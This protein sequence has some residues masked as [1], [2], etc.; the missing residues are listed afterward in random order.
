M[1]AT[2]NGAG[3]AS[4]F[5]PIAIIGMSSKFSGDAT[6][7]EKLWEMLAGGRSG[8]TPFPSSRFRLQGI[9]HP[10]NERL[11]STH[12]K[13]AHFLQEDIG[14]F[15]A[16]FFGYSSEAAASLDPQ[17]RLQLESVYEALESAGLPIS[18]IAGSNA[19]VFTG[20]F[21]HD[22]RDGLLR[23]ADNL[24]RLMATGTGV[25]MMS[26]RVSHFFDLRGASM[27]IE[28]ACSSGMVAMH[29]GI[30]S[31]RTGEADM[32]IV[33]G[34]NLTLNPDMFKALGSAG[35]LSGDGKSY[36]L[37]S[38]ASGYGRG[39]GVA[40]IIIKRLG[41][42]LA[43]GDP[44]RGVI[45]GSALN[46]DGKT[47]TI[48]TPSLEAQEA[49]IRAC[50]ENAGLSPKDTQ[51]FEA[52]GT[53]TQAGDTIEA[54]A[55]A[56]VF[57]SSSEPLLIGSVK[58]N[59][60]H[61]EAASG[62]ASIVKTVLALERGVIPPSIN[63]EKPNPK[64]PLED[65]RLRL[66][67]TLETWPAAAV[68]R[69]SINNF[70]YGGANAHIIMEESTP[71]LPALGGENGHAD[72]RSNE[73]PQASCE[74]T[75]STELN[76]RPKVLVL[77]GKDEQACQRMISNLGNFLELK[78]STRENAEAYL[79]S[80]TYTLGE[81]RTRFPWMAAYP[82]PTAANNF[83]AVVQTL[84]S[85]KFTPKRS[86]RQPRIGMVFT[87]Q[88]AQWHAMGR[89]L[90]AAYPV[91]K[92]SLEEAEKYLTRLGADWSL[93]E[94]LMRD[95]ESTRINS[96]AL[97]TPIC[98]AVQI[99]LVRLLRSWGVVPVAVTS[100]SSGELAAAYAAGAL[101][102]QK[103]M[104]FSY[105]R[106][107][108]AADK[109]LQAPVKGAM[110]AVG[111]GLEDTQSYLERLTSGG[112]AVVA[113][114][115]SPSS[116][117]VA[118]DLSAV[119]ELED[120]ANSEGVFARRLK[121]DTAWHSH[122]MARIA[123]VYAEALEGIQPEEGACDKEPFGPISFSSPVTG[124]RV[125]SA[126]AIS[127]PKHW[128]D[129]LVQPV[130]FVAALTDMVLGGGDG[131]SSNVDVIVEVGPH[132]ALGGPIQQTLAL[133]EFRDVRLPYYGCLVRKINAQD[134]MQALAASLLQEGYP[135][136]LKAV[137]FPNG[138]QHSVKVLPDLPSYPWNHQVK[139]WVEPR[140]NKALRE[141]TQP[142]HDLLG[143][144]VE[145]CNPMA[146]WWRHTL[147]I[148]ESPWTRD[149]VIQSNILYPAA[150]YLCLAIEAI[151]QLT[152]MDTTTSA[153][154][155]SGYR[156][157]D[158]DFLQALIIPESSDGIEIQ[159][160]MRPV[161]E[162]EVSVRG[163]RHF[164]VWTV[165]ADNRWTQHAKGLITV[166]LDGPEAFQPEAR[167]RDIRGYTRRT[168]PANLFVNLRAL[169]IAHGP[170]FQNMKSIIQ[171]G[172][173]PCSLVTMAVADICVPND[174]PRQ[175][176]LNPVT[177]DSVISA[178]YSTVPRSVRN[179]WVSS[180][181][182][183][184]A[185][186]LLEVHSQLT[187]N[188]DQGMEAEVSVSGDGQV[189]L[190]MDGFAYQSLG[191]NLSSQQ[192][193]PWKKELCSN[194]EWSLDISLSSPATILSIQK[195][196]GLNSC[197]KEHVK[198]ETL[199][200]CIGFMET[201]LVALGPIEVDSMDSSLA[202][203]YAWMKHTVQLAAS[204]Q[205]G[206]ESS[207]P[208]RD[209]DRTAA[210]RGY[211]EIVH[212]IG[213]QL[214][215]ILLGKVSPLDLMIQDNLLF[216]FYKE[217]PGVKTTGSQL[218]ELLRHLAHK[219]PRLRI[220]EVGAGAGA[221]TIHALEALGTDKSGGPRA[222]SYHYTDISA[223]FFDEARGRL[224][225]WKDVLSFDVLDI[226]R[227]PATQGFAIGTYDVVV[228]SRV[229]YG[230]RSISRTLDHVRNLL[231]PG[232]TLLF[233][234]D[235]QDQTEVQFVNGLLPGWYSPTEGPGTKATG[236]PL[237][238]EPVLDRHLRDAGFSGVD[239]G[240]YDSGNPEV[241]TS[242]A[243]MSRLADTP[244]P[245]LRVNPEQVAI[246]T[247]KKSGSPPSEW[248]QGLQKSIAAQ[249]YPHEEEE[250]K[251]P[252][253][254]D[255]DSAS[256]AAAWYT[257]KICIFVGEMSEPILYDLDPAALEGLR[258]MSTNSKGLLWVTS[259][260]AVDCERPELSLAPGFIRS[261][262]T[263]YTGRKF[264]TLDLD[265]RGPL[266][267]DAGAS[268]ITRVLQAAFGNGAEHSTA[269]GAADPTDFEYAERD[270]II[271]VPRFSHDVAKDRL[272]SSR[273]AGSDGQDE[274]STEPFFQANRPLCLSPASLA[275]TDDSYAGG[276]VDG[277]APG[278]VE[279]EP[280][281][282]GISLHDTDKRIASRECAGV[283][284]RVGSAALEQGYAVGDRVFCLLRQSSL[285]SCVVVE[286][287]SAMPIPA[288]L[289]F[290]DAATMPLAF[291]T[292]YYS[293]VQVARLRQGQ[294]VL[295]TDA[296]AE[297]G[298][299]AIMIARHLKAEIFATV[300]SPEEQEWVTR[301]YG[302][303]AD[304]ILDSRNASFGA[305]LLASTECRGVDVVLNT[306]KGPL[307]QKSFGL[308]APLGSFV[309]IGRHD[310]DQN[311][312]LEMRPFARHVSF[313]AVD[314]PTLLEHGGSD[315]H[316]CLREVIRLLEAKGIAP[317]H[318]PSVHCPGDLAEVQD[319]LKTGTHLGNVILSVDSDA[320]VSVLPRK[321]AV[322][323]SRDASYMIVGGTGGLGRSVA[324]W[325]ASRGAK[326]LVIMS[327]N[328][329]KSEKTA[330]LALELREAGCSRV[331]LISGD[332]AREDDVANAIQTCA[333]EGLPP[334]RGVIHAAFALRDSFVEKMTLDDY[335]TTIDSKVAG[336]WNLHNQ[337]NLP[338][339]LDFFVMFSSINGIVGY[340]SQAAYSA[341]GAYEDA[342][343]HYRVKQCGLPAVS[344]DL[345]VVDDVGYVAEASSAEVLRNSLVKAGRMVIDEDQ[346]L[347]ALE[348][349]ILSPY[350]PQFIMGGI[351][352]GPGPHWDVSSDLGRDMRFLPLKYRQ[353]SSSTESQQD[354]EQGDSLAAKMAGCAS[355]DE[356][357]GLVESAL[358][359][360]LSDMFLVPVE[361]IDMT[362]S[363]TQQGVDSLMAVEVR[364]MLFSQAGAELSIFNILQSPSLARLAADV[365][366]RSVHV[367]ISDA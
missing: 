11:N 78:G 185:G 357:I 206:L 25:P 65:W 119:V 114:V 243:V 315:V 261:L 18:T 85:P 164:E 279:I 202:E 248:V 208:S 196:L 53:G 262:R 153:Q 211:G 99:S 43:A 227:D 277:L 268:A 294:S 79:Q 346:V 144:L 111:L 344:I 146:P 332:V 319:A 17:Y 171:S 296:V 246:I 34:A 192:A 52:H 128:V 73:S 172:S 295:I 338:G 178:P 330:A 297:V 311:S 347:A 304:R 117:T 212:R 120:L 274:V 87:G 245:K 336:V 239:L 267:S 215:D 62:L 77:S 283:V 305:A 314:V 184:V 236:R 49:L 273:L 334:I 209:A 265:P 310:V 91:Y 280:K 24:P 129:S 96:V 335:K 50:Y 289:S 21:V 174:L 244:S 72:G 249:R 326:N 230:T 58:T 55:I 307:L 275:F 115:N 59:L 252:V 235:L 320:M 173:E 135:V 82:V 186:H 20:V 291:L 234:E 36:A 313:S 168:S 266:W 359:E 10:N 170:M 325:M 290:Q 318:R 306:L 303:S 47:E 355:R 360:M 317:F 285:P 45:R 278:L 92:A 122:H 197:P 324:H 216:R 342:M 337:F 176:V 166:E 97:S 39:E 312:L 4:S 201:A 322:C 71:W 70:G 60:G 240:L 198:R 354:Q 200:A 247:S 191:Q 81:R 264:L 269:I 181:I 182:S 22:Y 257:D 126:E 250:Q 204:G 104:A 328:A 365:V 299:A 242:V 19:S 187:R 333:E 340:P 94:E 156:L 223:A 345:S 133:P 8:W 1:R 76:S 137:N 167:N 179:S 140:C 44:I 282:Y 287:T 189:V 46:Q 7:N 152:A 42:A 237:L 157:Q 350:S 253:V 40:T 207:E 107:S 229:L 16:A 150:G 281:A 293:L 84:R 48:T 139:H 110:I 309:D 121:V 263:E 89:E 188:D 112:K 292:A 205:L 125:A 217:S 66:V 113:C 141:R 32:S 210:S 362:E 61:T 151:K 218:A 349:S 105:F 3:D 301:K 93:T 98:V 35:F 256:A 233:A 130:Q 254:Q 90:I 69:A 57:S 221:M 194:V 103:A 316:R 241:S 352:S 286:W 80:L 367:N 131:S 224:S 329:S 14:L 222:S 15:D 271:L 180:K 54:R 251:L 100:H 86:S 74:N 154:G 361:D 118:G 190:E 64:I 109:S 163:W 28:T 203:H 339:D 228:A 37:D 327:R 232:G 260:G 38:R 6:D 41:D 148:S 169:G 356:A 116:I 270:G 175:H 255:I 51:Y 95:A 177:L 136:D 149:H 193:Q 63:F 5:E 308:V 160:S 68:R 2:S 213:G 124:G 56:S 272:I 138:R 321:T 158:V 31:L 298:Q 366:T 195:R 348:S 220:L 302:L 155:I 231:K 75:T 238:S 88:G 26:N 288:Q 199:R 183:N 123:S 145:G 276:F 358:A 162:K 30:Q 33:G 101:S 226:E 83:D 219:N 127:R 134:T 259:G 13:G 12:V 108:L 351:N 214:A 284:R 341:A 258:A 102:Y 300:G 132:T 27:T 165:T 161:G 106:A 29:Q 363:P 9:Y 343:A 159:T 67:R 143:S 364:N 331:L 23:D 323:L 142:P 225:S 353:A 147:R